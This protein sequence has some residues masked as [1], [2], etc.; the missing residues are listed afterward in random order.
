MHTQTMDKVL[1]VMSIILHLNVQQMRSICVGV[2]QYNHET[3]SVVQFIVM[4]RPNYSYVS[5]MAF[6]L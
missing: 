3:S 4:F 5:Q 1:S 2:H 6:I